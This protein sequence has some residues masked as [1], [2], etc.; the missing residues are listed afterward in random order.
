MILLSLLMHGMKTFSSINSANFI[1]N[2][3]LNMVGFMSVG[4]GYIVKTDPFCDEFYC[5]CIIC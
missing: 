3:F 2:D 4:D 1:E 5:A